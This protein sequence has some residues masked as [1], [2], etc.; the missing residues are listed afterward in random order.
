MSIKSC[1]TC[2]WHWPN[3]EPQACCHGHGDF[4]PCDERGWCEDWELDVRHVG[5]TC[6]WRLEHS[7]TLYDKWRCSKCGY[8]FVEPRCDQGYNGMDPNFCPSCGRKAA[9]A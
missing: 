7:G 2:N 8:L 4:W 9:T 1:R 5:E 3:K 6:E